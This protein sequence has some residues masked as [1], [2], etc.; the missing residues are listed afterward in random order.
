[1]KTLKKCLAI[2]LVLLTLFSIFSAATTAFAEEYAEQKARG[3]YFDSVLSG[4]LKNI[5]D[6]KDAV[7]IFEKEQTAE[8]VEEANSS[9]TR[10]SNT[11]SLRA[12]SFQSTETAKEKEEELDIDHTRLTLELEDGENVAYLFSE[13]ISFIDNTGN[14][15][16]KDTNIK[17]VTDSV[18]I[19]RGYLYENGNNDYKAYFSEDSTKGLLLVDKNDKE[20]RLVPNGK[21]VVGAV[22][23]VESDMN[24]VDSFEYDGIYG[25]DT[26][27]RFL[28]QL[29]GCKEEIVL[30]SY[31]GI[32]DFSF[33]LYTQE[34]TIAAINS[35]GE[36]EIIDSVTKDIITT[37]V[38]PFANDS[39]G[40]LD[41]TSEHY[42]DC[43][44]ELEMITQGEYLLTISVPKEYLESEN[45]VYP[46]IIDPTTDN[47]SMYLDTSVYSALSDN[48]QGSNPTA[49]FGK[50]SSSE[51]GKGRAMFHFKLP[52]D[53]KNYA[54]I[55]SAKLWLRETTGRTAEMHVR[56]YLISESWTNQ[57]T[58]DTQPKYYNGTAD[59]PGKS[60]FSLPR[61]NIN[62]TSTDNPNSPYWYAFDIVYAV[63]AWTTGTTNSGLKFI[64]ECEAADGDYSWRAFATKEHTTSSYRP[65]VVISYTNDTTKPTISSVSGN[66]TAWTKDDVT[67]T[68]TATDNVYGVNGIAGYSFD[69]G[70]TWQTGK[71][72]TFS[73][74]QTVYIKV[75]D[76]A[77]NVSAATTIKISKIDKSKPTVTVTLS[78][79]SWTNS[80]VTATIT[81]ADN[82]AIAKYTINDTTTTLDADG[83][84]GITSKTITKTY[85]SNTTVSVS[86]VD[87]AG[88]TSSTVSKSF[89]N[90]DKT[91]PSA[92]I[93]LSTTSVTN[94][95][96]TA[97]I[98]MTDN[99]ALASY[100]LDGASAVTISGT[101]KTITKTYSKNQTISLTVKDA[102]GNSYTA[103]KDI[104]NIDKT[105]PS[106]TI[107]L[108]PTSWTN[109]SV[110]ATIKMT[111]NVGLKSYSLDGASAVTISGTSKTIT[112]TYSANDTIDITVTDTAGNSATVSKSFTN[113]D[114]TKPS[115]T[116]TLSPTSWTNGSVTA[117][118]KMTDNAALA[119]YTLDDASAVTI[120]GTSKT[121]TKTYSA[122]DT[123]SLTVKD[124]A[125]NTYTT[126]K[127]ITNIDK[128]KPSATI[129]ISST[130]W[131]NGSVT[132]TIKM[133]D[134]AA[135]AS[136]TLDG[137]S[138]VTISGTSKTVTK[139]YSSNDT[140]SLTV[141]DAAGNTY[142]TSKSITNIDK[143]KPSATITLSPTSW[144]NDSV[145][146]TIKMTD[147]AALA[148]YTLDGASAVTIS[149]TSKTVT[150]T[151]SANDTI[152]L[153]I[154]DAAGNTYTTSK[155]I[156]NIDKTKPSATITI[157]STS[158]TNGSVTATIKMT[159]NAAL[160]SYTLDGA[161]AVTISGTSKTV[162]KTYS[163]NDTIS[164][165]VKDAAGN[166]YTTSKSITNIDKTKPSATITIS[167][168]SWTNGSVTATIKMTDNAALASYTLDGASA[169]TISGTSKT[170]T[171]T[172]S[173]NDTISL[174]VKDAAGNTYTTSKSIT[175]IDKS[176]PV[177]SVSSETTSVSSK[178]TVNA[179]DAGAGLHETA[180]CYNTGNWT[181]DNFLYV[182]DSSEVTIKVRDIA[183]N[184]YT[185]TYT[186]E[187]KPEI[188]VA[189]EPQGWTCGDVTVTVNGTGLTKY[190]FDNGESWQNGNVLSVSENG[191]III[192]V[193][194][195]FGNTV[196]VGNYEIDV[197]DKVSPGIT[198][199]N[200][201]EITWTYKP[202]TVEI[203][204]N[205]EISGI[206]EYSFDG[207]E[208][209]QAENV[210]IFDKNE[211]EVYPEYIFVMV[212]DNAGN[213]AQ[214]D[215]ISLVPKDTIVPASPDLY[216]E[217]GLVYIS[218][219]SFN[220]NEDTDSVE[221]IEYKLGNGEWTA[222]NDEP[223]NI[224][225]TC[226]TAVY[227][228]VVDEAG[229]I[230][231]I[232]SYTLE[233]TLGKYT[234]SYTDIALGEGL[235]PVEF[236]RTYTSTN[237][238]FFTFDANIQPFTNGYVF[239]DFYGEKQ[240]F[241]K[242]GEDKYIS[243]EEEELTINGDSFV[244]TYG[245][246]TCTFGLDGKITRIVTD[247]LDTQYTWNN[248]GTLTVT[249]GAAVTFTDGKPTKISITRAGQIK[250]VEYVWT[251][252]NLTKFIDAADA[253][254]NYAYTNGLLTTN[255]TET[256]TYS[257]EG[258]VKLIS[259]PNGAFVKYTYND[260]A[261]N[262]QIPNNV[263]TVT[264]SDSKGVTDTLCYAD[265]VYISN[266]LDGYSENAV[267]APESISTSLAQDNITDVF[268]V[269]EVPEEDEST[270]G[271]DVQSD[272]AESE[273]P[274]D[275]ETTEENGEETADETP[276]YTEIDENTYAFYIYDEQ[277]RVTAELEALKVNIAID[278]NTA[279]EN[280]EAVAESKIT[281]TY[282]SDED[283]SIIEQT[284]YIKSQNGLVI[285]EKECYTYENGDVKSHSKY[286]YIDGAAIILYNESYE[287]NDYGNVETHTETQYATDIDAFD[288]TYI[289][290]YSY[291]IWGMC[292]GITVTCGDDV[293]TTLTE[294]DLNGVILSVTY[295][296]EKII[297]TYTD[298]G[299]VDKETVIKLNGETETVRQETDYTY[300]TA[301][302]LISC[303]N[304]DGDTSYY[305]YDAYGNLTNHNFNGYFFTY[306]TLGS[307][308]TASVH[309]DVLV[310]YTY[311]GAEQELS[312]VQYANGQ[313]INYTYN[314]ATGELLA[315]SQGEETKFSYS[316]S[317][318]S[319]ITTLTDNINNIIKV[320]ESDKVTVKANADTI[321]YSVE[322]LYEDEEKEGSFNGK[323]ITVG[324]DVYT[325]K[326]EENKDSF[327]TGET[328]DFIKTYEYDYAGNLWKVNTANAVS[329][330]YGY[331]EDKNVSTLKNSLN[332]LVQTFG[333]GY[334]NEGNITTETLNIV[335]SDEVGAT[336]ETNEAVNY[337]YDEDNQLLSAETA[338]TKWVY[339]YDGRGNM[340]SKTQYSVT[341]NENND[342]V[343]T[344]VDSKEYVYGDAVWADKLTEYDNVVIEYD[345]LGNPV[346]YLGNTLTWTMG[347]QLATF[348][349]ISYTYN[350]DGIRTS[351]TVNN[352][353]TTYY[354][355]GTNIIEQSDGTNTL[356]FYYD[357]NDE[358]I[359][360]TYNEADYFY[361]KNA[362]SDIIGIVDDSGNL[363]TSYTYD[364]WGKEL[365]VTGSNTELGNLN[366]FRYRSYYYDSD[367]EMYYLQSRYYAPE[368]CR[369]INSDDVTFIGVTG[370]VNS[371][372]S[373]AYCE[374]NPVNNSDPT[375]NFIVRRWMI[376]LFLDLVFTAIPVI[377]GIFAPIKYAAKKMGLAL[378]KS[379]FTGNIFKS[380]KWIISN[381]V[382]VA[383][384]II[385]VVKKVPILKK[386]KF[387]QN[388]SA[389]KIA[390]SLLGVAFFKTPTYK[391]LDLVIK[392]VDI[393]L[394]LGGF[395]SGLLDYAFDKK[396]NNKIWEF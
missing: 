377:G 284:S 360:F 112:K 226:E 378:V 317:D 62:S 192:N 117:T 172:Y 211:D 63:R 162:T 160:A 333:Y 373:F 178:I 275:N 298:F 372:N 61:R 309:N 238:W 164:L 77:G 71:S 339:T 43:T 241:I 239:T 208:S 67:L 88:N 45:T 170:V 331:N 167:S 358:I 350:E 235:F 78:P 245:D 271:T 87:A 393:V 371:Y 347:R 40:G 279:F 137:A 69:N 193:T 22:N 99:A 380:V 272:E 285:D 123:I 194:D 49:C 151:Y 7:K 58:W 127:S 253:E 181:N 355:D 37:F 34:G 60:N 109:S 110:T 312:S 388:L 177:V 295:N 169:V 73:K 83:S 249:G 24:L 89:T 273:E 299:T 383:N 53:I 314:E 290:S 236:G 274:K 262:T 224:V 168:T 147:N 210:K 94:S 118:I 38:A 366:P 93:S 281:Y 389:N 259:Q 324:T 46:V 220:F 367:I 153:T 11:F 150:K 240:Y 231:A 345:A 214:W 326:S 76:K 183:G 322:N 384:K 27:L 95:S 107:T 155:S 247:Y 320:I 343:Y 121:V 276:L 364:A 119:S 319:E 237:G 14:L 215:K 70:E 41:I 316:Y 392:N 336:V 213:T 120:S 47:I 26:V 105:K 66:P 199:V 81:I 202:V 308:L 327:F 362:M 161:S 101:S 255:E 165:T 264:V 267:Y 307:I 33:T 125:G 23:Q 258:R 297:Y 10:R 184:I 156:T 359:G 133:T 323:K 146:A 3:K 390:G 282:L 159:D 39:S 54:Q 12:T 394:S 370:T 129:T 59:Y 318:D 348:G 104:T 256:I 330:Q 221:H 132:A 294:Y 206:S 379:Q 35:N 223:L 91:K 304:P 44:Y 201:S 6:T 90:I 13:P 363:I 50:T 340:T 143:T 185:T 113:I 222:Y 175:N 396:V 140:I 387:I 174:T 32:S 375:G 283:D 288:I 217:N 246:M 55:S 269:V 385:N 203:T 80:S 154:K 325:L 212:K 365:S 260:N 188:N 176:A 351:K 182:T 334:D 200:V 158:W 391:L 395:I 36:V 31:Q 2:F 116:I 111:D 270:D 251:D 115:A 305:Y 139:T 4:Y 52:E 197:I 190:S 232:A 306:N 205:D 352:V 92:T 287:Y 79:T 108:S 74:N 20:V 134:N 15:V 204:A 148:S 86:V 277:N 315:V 189:V 301:G 17:A 142:T 292:T 144:T 96:V 8:T 75:K 346:N 266:T 51:Y 126:S 349:D 198:D 354:L 57:A 265:G 218:S 254:H 180:Y 82:A 29:N 209:W 356:H 42:T 303:L 337:I 248:D 84:E 68:V 5:I 136:Y 152:S 225:R 368:I 141:K 243:V 300:D 187:E 85:S 369:F 48:P 64:A 106:A 191:N 250:E 280:A 386:A 381:V 310:T 242:N 328:Q 195:A 9:V 114:K 291:D 30:S 311:N 289:T 98:K 357:G 72:K 186:P 286:K 313:T 341:I 216:E 233:N 296:D 329:T 138:A 376:S 16:Y 179:S 19:N 207:G 278:E 338:D 130:S 149:G 293:D 234:A 230:S 229:N 25:T 56:P 361:V 28:P 122:N 332:G 374:N 163:A 145:T 97:T 21:K 173:A 18:I 1:M 257:A 227:A 252:G 100:T 261:E 128:T 131:T 102:A 219:R 244:L 135:L 321:L 353:T 344:Q 171:K 263:G 342:K 65:Y 124:A 382:K 302:N 157:S 166:T 196:N 268:Y 228:R 103:T 335:T